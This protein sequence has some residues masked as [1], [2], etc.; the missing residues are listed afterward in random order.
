MGYLIEALGLGSRE[1]VSLVGAGGKTTL[2]FRLSEEL[3]ND[4]RRVVT[5]TTTKIFEPSSLEAPFL[6]VDK[7]E[8]RI[9]HFLKD[10]FFAKYF[11]LTLASER[12]ES[13]KL[14]GLPPDLID[15]LWE[16]YNIEYI[17]IEADGAKRK[18]IKAPRESEPIIPSSTTLVI[19]LLGLDGLGQ[20]LNE[21]HVFQAERVSKLTETPLGSIITEDTLVRLAIHPEGLFKGSPSE[22]RRIAFLNK[23]DHLKEKEKAK[24]MAQNILKKGHRQIERVL[25]GQ[26]RFTPPVIEIILA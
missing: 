20:E 15:K 9:K 2:M 7:N 14:R 1:M 3:F 23:I 13:G 16:E 10:F 8:E 22:S 26:L 4:K 12:I 11:H 17:I 25:L 19:G 18:S 24:R 6:F 21:E 5:T